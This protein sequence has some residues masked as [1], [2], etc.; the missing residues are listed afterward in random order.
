MIGEH[1]LWIGRIGSAV[2]GWRYLKCIKNNFTFRYDYAFN[3]PSKHDFLILNSILD[4]R[5]RRC[6]RC[7]RC[8]WNLMMNTTILLRALCSTL[9]ISFSPLL[10]LLLLRLCSIVYSFSFAHGAMRCDL[11]SDDCRNKF[12]RKI[13]NYEMKNKNAET[14]SQNNKRKDRRHS[15]A[16][17]K[18]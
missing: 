1:I 13:C 4:D 12:S 9:P 11:D 16:S 6:R 10:A 2:I 15:V 3:T 18:W 14:K 7:R 8:R 17:D 5:V